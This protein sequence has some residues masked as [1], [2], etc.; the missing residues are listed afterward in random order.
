MSRYYIN[1]SNKGRTDECAVIGYDRPLRTFF[2]QGFISQDSDF[3][4]PEIW[5][6]T[7]LEEFPTLESLV[8]EARARGYEIG[9]LKRA[10]IIAM[11]AEAGQRHEPTIWERLGLIF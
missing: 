7:V 1:L 11:L 2:L 6:G 5:L 3:D 9:Q 10:D 8:E 4:E